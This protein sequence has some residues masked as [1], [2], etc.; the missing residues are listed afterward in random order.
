MLR[1]T[2]RLLCD[3][4]QH[5]VDP[6][7]RNSHLSNQRGLRRGRSRFEAMLELG[8]LR[9]LGWLCAWLVAAGLMATMH[10]AAVRIVA[11]LVHS[12]RLS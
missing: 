7:F 4:A 6:S 10:R 1:T 11:L 5:L 12:S 9:G 8:V 3:E 2:Y